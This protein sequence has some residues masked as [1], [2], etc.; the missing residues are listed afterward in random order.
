MS[1]SSFRPAT[2]EQHLFPYGEGHGQVLISLVWFASSRMA[3]LT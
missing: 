1:Y 3:W 2:Q